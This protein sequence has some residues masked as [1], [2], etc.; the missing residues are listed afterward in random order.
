VMATLNATMKTIICF[1]ITILFRKYFLE[2]SG[3]AN[4]SIAKNTTKIKRKNTTKIKRKNTTKIKRKN[5]NGVFKEEETSFFYK[6][7]LIF[8][9]H[10]F[11]LQ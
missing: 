5:A 9:A 4:A 8:M 1:N 6:S 2:K 11:T 3:S 7:F 10:L